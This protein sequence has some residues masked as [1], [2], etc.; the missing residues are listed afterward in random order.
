MNR[1]NFIRFVGSA[2]SVASVYQSGLLRMHAAPHPYMGEFGQVVSEDPDRILI[3]LRLWGGNDGLNTIVPIDNHVYYDARLKYSEYDISIKPEQTIPIESRSGYGWHPSLG[4]LNTLYNEGKVAVIQGV[5]YPNM[6]LSHFRSTGIWLAGGDP[7]EILRTGWIGRH[8]EREIENSRTREL[9]NPIGYPYALEFGPVVGNVLAGHKGVIG[10]SL[11]PDILTT[12]APEY[13]SEGLN[14][15]S[16]E[17]E[18]IAAKMFTEGA[19][20]VDLVREARRTHPATHL[21]EKESSLARICSI[22]SSCIRSGLGTPVYMVHTGMFDFH[23]EQIQLQADE[24]HTTFDALY[25]LQRELEESGDAKRVCILVFS[26]F[27]RRVDT[28]YSGT[29]HGTSAPVFVI[30]S[31]VNGGFYGEHPSLSNLD[32]N[33]NLPWHID[34][35]QIYWSLL[36]EWLQTPED[37]LT[38][39][40]LSKPFP[41]LGLFTSPSPVS[42]ITS[43]SNTVALWPQ[44]ASTN[45]TVGPLNVP[46]NTRATV[47][48]CTMNGSTASETHAV[49]SNG[50]IQLNVSQLSIGTY[51]VHITTGALNAVAW[52]MKS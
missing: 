41:L 9:E 51:L 35:R 36:R 32:R 31:E 11:D 45:A 1:R 39:N 2:A 13:L 33:N 40:I 28:T 19:D 12:H 3:V 49:V 47:R 8:L 22:I 29:D 17:R 20:Y 14:E 50:E 38:P 25:K 10:H 27:G 30:S 15:L 34:F 4:N 24:L 46:N 44:P 43:T 23:E 26:E 42:T 18:A 7:G 37:E 6:D 16:F 52:L 21:N 48:I 5:G